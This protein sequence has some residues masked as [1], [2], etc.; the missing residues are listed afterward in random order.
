MRERHQRARVQDCGA[1]WRICYWD[2]RS[3][4]RSGR[5]K[6]RAKSTTRSPSENCILKAASAAENRI[7]NTARQSSPHEARS[8]C[9]EKGFPIALLTFVSGLSWSFLARSIAEPM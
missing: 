2:Y 4:K 5:T 6:S 9:L 3:R 1:K 7:V 8:K